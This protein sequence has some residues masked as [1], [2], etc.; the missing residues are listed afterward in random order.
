MSNL[1]KRA[2]SAVGRW[3]NRN[4]EL[5]N[6]T[7][8][9][10]IERIG[11]AVKEFPE[12]LDP[13]RQSNPELSSL[14]ASGDPWDDALSSSE[15]KARQD[16]D[17]AIEAAINAGQFDDSTA[18]P[19]DSASILPAGANLL[20]SEV[21]HPAEPALL[22]SVA[23]V[24]APVVEEIKPPI[25]LKPEP[26]AAPIP[27]PEPSVSFT[28]LYELISTEVNKRT[29]N[30]VNVYERL[31]AATREELEATRRSNRLA[32]SVGGVMTAVAAVG[33]VWAA[34]EVSATRVEVSSLRQQVVTGQQ[35]SADRDLLRAE[36]IK[37]RE[38]VAKIEID[39]LKSRLDQAIALSADRDRLRG[40][41]ETVRKAKQETEIELRTEL[42]LARA[43]ATQPVSQAVPASD[44]SK[45]AGSER[46]DAW[47]ILLNG[48]DGR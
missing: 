24:P 3:T 40:E 12:S 46:S 10:L 35:A 9:A 14:S 17:A 31:L 5:E 32:W 1:F 19:L 21:Q 28:Q 48:L 41:L 29:D 16:T 11:E 34:G 43:A 36:L 22:Q 30:T 45:V 47:S 38:T 2:A 7:N 26:V 25:E 39:A 18:Q 33:A 37:A 20:T 42:R 6:Q 8:S 23:E 4:R 13:G 44:K 27:S 15:S